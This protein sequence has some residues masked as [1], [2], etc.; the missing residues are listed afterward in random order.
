MTIGVC[1]LTLRLPE[2]HSLKEKRQV[3]KS[4]TSRVRNRFNVSIAEVDENDR[5][6]LAV[7]GISCV[8]NGPQH[9]QQVISTVVDFIERERPDVEIVDYQVE[10]IPN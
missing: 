4:I 9:A 7:L 6:Q 3:L 2:N 1:R 10:I 8:S 5:W